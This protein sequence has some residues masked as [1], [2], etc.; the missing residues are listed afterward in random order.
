MVSTE[1][2]QVLERVRP[3]ARQ[4]QVVCPRMQTNRASRYADRPEALGGL[5]RLQGTLDSEEPVG[6]FVGETVESTAGD[7]DGL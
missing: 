3:A 6:K 5:A 1:T 7:R 4:A 2:R